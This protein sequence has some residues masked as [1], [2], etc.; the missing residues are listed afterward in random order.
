[1]V[2][3]VHCI[4]A[5]RALSN[6]HTVQIVNNAF[7]QNLEFL[8]DFPSLTAL[9]VHNASALT[10][11][12]YITQLVELR[13]S[14]CRNISPSDFVGIGHFTHLTALHAGYC[15]QIQQNT[16][17]R[18]TR[19]QNLR[20]LSIEAIQLRDTVGLNALF[21]ASKR[22]ERFS[23][24]EGKLPLTTHTWQYVPPSLTSLN[25]DDCDWLSP[26]TVSELAQFVPQL[27]E[28]FFYFV[29]YSWLRQPVSVETIDFGLLLN[30]TEL[31]IATTRNQFFQA[32]YPH[33]TLHFH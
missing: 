19:L 6:L 3:N 32:K 13:L 29:N 8:E 1:M 11:I 21:R 18:W 24:A 33:L 22:L 9:D 16:L 14:W 10:S 20:E 31:S 26:T 30:L 28:L 4:T 25:L 7:N 2:S 12:P 23:Y 17:K 15:P 5:L 27:R